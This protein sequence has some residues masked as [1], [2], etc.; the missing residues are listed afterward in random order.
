VNEQLLAHIDL[1]DHASLATSLRGTVRRSLRALDSGTEPSQLSGLQA[2]QVDRM[3][4]MLL[5]SAAGSGMNT[6]GRLVP[7]PAARRP[8]SHTERRTM[9]D[10][11]RRLA[12][13]GDGEPTVEWVVNATQILEAIRSH[14]MAQ[15]TDDQLSFVRAQL[16]PFLRKLSDVDQDISD[17]RRPE[18]SRQR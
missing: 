10:L 6:S 14:G 11:V 15:L 8:R 3:I 13:T 18:F 4:S 16:E 1:R 9:Y 12:A 2:K 5:D 17:S 7:D